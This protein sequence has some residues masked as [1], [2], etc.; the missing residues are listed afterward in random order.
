MW[1]KVLNF[2]FW[3]FVLVIVGFLQTSFSF[4]VFGLKPNLI[5]ILL[6]FLSVSRVSLL[7]FLP[8]LLI[9][10]SV[11]AWEPLIGPES[12][13]IFVVCLV[14]YISR[15][16]FSFD[17]PLSFLILVAIA[18]V[19]FYLALDY[20]FVLDYYLIVAYEAVLNL[21]LASILIISYR[22]LLKLD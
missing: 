17:R 3:S 1:N 6:L 5:L 21:A 16:L 4:G 18:S 20:K 8:L 2:I 14:V 10:I 9:G 15:R 19:I 7:E 22:L 13:I 11:V 12:A